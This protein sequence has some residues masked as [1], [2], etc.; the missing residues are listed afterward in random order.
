[1]KGNFLLEMKHD[2]I[3][4]TIMLSVRTGHTLRVGV[5]VR[6]RAEEIGLIDAL[7]DD[8]E[9][10]KLGLT[11]HRTGRA[12][13]IGQTALQF[14]YPSDPF[15]IRRLRG[16]LFDELV[17]DEDL[18]VFAGL[19]HIIAYVGR[20]ARVRRVHEDIKPLRELAWN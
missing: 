9:V 4:E 1:M 3:K 20:K 8:D 11:Y 16:V 5:F 13:K 14:I 17:I 12:A 6:N 18:P 19:E 10:I 15:E 2:L 7:A